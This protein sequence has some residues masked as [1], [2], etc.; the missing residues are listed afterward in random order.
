MQLPKVPT[1][2][3]KRTVFVGE[4]NKF[5]PFLLGTSNDYARQAACSLGAARQI[6]PA[7]GTEQRCQQLEV[8]PVRGN[9]E[10]TAGKLSNFL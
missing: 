9:R 8:E 10:E 3:L 2:A 6:P 7:F 5:K 4:K 1:D